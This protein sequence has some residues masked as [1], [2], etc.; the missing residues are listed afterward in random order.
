MRWPG[1]RSIFLALLPMAAACSNASLLS[2]PPPPQ[3]QPEAEVADKRV[4]V[5][6]AVIV[7]GTPTGVYSQVARGALQCWFGAD[8]PLKPSHVFEA[9]AEPPAKGGAAEIV[10]YERDETLRD[11]R[12][13]RAL[14]VAIAS[15]SNS[16]R[17]ATTVMRLEARTAQHMTK[18]VEVWARGGQGCELR[19][20]MQPAPPSAQ[21]ASK[22][23]SGS[24]GGKKR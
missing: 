3:V 22:G 13:A 11:K 20:H 18:D 7:P 23:K 21:E 19:A 10:L 15:A 16:V 2:L 6:T 9:E 17:V 4:P 12:G 1:L 5:E 24:P 14:R 8:G